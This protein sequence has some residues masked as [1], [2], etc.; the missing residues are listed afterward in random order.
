MAYKRA[1][2]STFDA[3]PPKRRRTPFGYV[4]ME[5]DSMPKAAQATSTSKSSLGFFDLPRELR[6]KIYSLVLASEEGDRAMLEPITEVQADELRV[7]EERRLQYGSLKRCPCGSYH[8]PKR[9][10]PRKALDMSLFLANRQAWTEGNEVLLRESL[11]K[12]TGEIDRPLPSLRRRYKTILQQARH[13]HLTIDTVDRQ[14]WWLKI[15]QARTN[16][17]S[18]DIV[19]RDGDFGHKWVQYEKKA[20]DDLRALAKVEVLDLARVSYGPRFWYPAWVRREVQEFVNV[21]LG[22]RFQGGWAYP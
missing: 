12:F 20:R 19:I 8:K 14:A 11:I 3:L 21:E 9:P 7:R 18:L 16:I 10:L 6:D 15:L 1:A 17:R 5:V 13:I 2:S 4:M 22:P